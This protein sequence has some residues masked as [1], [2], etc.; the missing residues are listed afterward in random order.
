MIERFNA[1]LHS[2]FCQLFS[3]RFN[4]QALHFAVEKQDLATVEI[5]L[6][7]VKYIAHEHVI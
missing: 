4:L 6:A 3:K 2:L 1:R 7:T 5:I